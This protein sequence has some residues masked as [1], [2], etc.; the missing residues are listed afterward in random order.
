MM[1]IRN[2]FVTVENVEDVE[3][4]YQSSY[5]EYYI[6]VRWCPGGVVLSSTSIAQSIP[7]MSGSGLNNI[8]FMRIISIYYT[9]L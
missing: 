9:Y 1:Q 3:G 2:C 5:N 7:T 4:R 8:R 6:I